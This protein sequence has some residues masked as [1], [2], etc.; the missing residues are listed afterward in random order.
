MY[1]AYDRE[2]L[3][4]YEAVKHFRH[5][6]EAHHL[7]I[8]TDHK[9]MTYAFQQNREKCSPRQFNHLGFVAQF[10]T[11]IRHIFAQDNVLADALFTAESITAPPSYDALA[12]S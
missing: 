5:M 11:D 4:I 3:V 2:L 6:L 12:P 1:S 10:S 8:F 7:I 9:S